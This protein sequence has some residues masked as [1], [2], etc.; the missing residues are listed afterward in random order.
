MPISP[1]WVIT[2]EGDED[3]ESLTTKSGVFAPVL[4]ASTDNNP[5]GEVVF[6]PDSP[7]SCTVN[8]VDDAIS[9]TR[10][11]TDEVDPLP[12]TVSRAGAVVVP[13]ERFPDVLIRVRSSILKERLPDARRSVDAP[14]RII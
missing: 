2:K 10:N 6:D 8:S 5:Q 11:A 1:V 13:M 4:I 7:V 12:H 9:D 3:A 14:S